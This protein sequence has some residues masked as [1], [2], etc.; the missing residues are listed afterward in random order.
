[1]VE[2]QN[3]LNAPRSCYIQR[4]IQLQYCTIDHSLMILTSKYHN[5]SIDLSCPVVRSLLHVD[6]NMY[7]GQWRI[8]QSEKEHPL[9]TFQVYIFKSVQMPVLAYF[10]TL[11]ISTIFLPPITVYK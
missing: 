1:M 10:F 6:F 8:Q 9:G 7:S 3:F 2:L 4:E 11:N 5:K